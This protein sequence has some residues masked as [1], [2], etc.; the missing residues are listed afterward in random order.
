MLGALNEHELWVDDGEHPDRHAVEL[1]CN[2]ELAVQL[3]L[4]TIS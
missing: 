4:H 2:D 1:G 3:D